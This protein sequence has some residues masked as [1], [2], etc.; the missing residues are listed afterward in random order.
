MDRDVDTAYTMWSFRHRPC[1]LDGQPV[2]GDTVSPAE[3]S[4]EVRNTAC[5]RPDIQFDWAH[6]GILPPILNRLVGD[7]S[8]LPAHDVIPCPAVKGRREFHSDFS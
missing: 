2:S 1:R 3:L 4:D 8:M 7:D 6:A 5:D